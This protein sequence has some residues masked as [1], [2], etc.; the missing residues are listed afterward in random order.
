MA[1]K[2][3]KELLNAGMLL[4][5]QKPGSDVQQNFQKHRVILGGAEPKINVNATSKQCDLGPSRFRGQDQI[6]R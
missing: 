6:Q 1:A 5:Q 3:S 4:E 2:M